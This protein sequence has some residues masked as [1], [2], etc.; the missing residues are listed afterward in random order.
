[1][2]TEPEP[3]G[4]APGGSS[5]NARWLARVVT[6]LLA[7]AGLIW[8]ASV[9]A[10]L[11]DPAIPRVASRVA[12][13]ESYDPAL[14]RRMVAEN[15]QSAQR[16]CNAK[17]LRQ[18][19]ILQIGAAE[20]SIR[21]PDLRQADADIADIAQMSRTLLGCAPTESI[22]WLGAYWSNIRQEGFGPRAAVYLG[23]SYRSA[24]HEAWIQLVR[25]P[26]ALRSF[27]ALSPELK[28]A[29]LQD[30]DD[31][32]RAQLFSSAAMLLKT[33]VASAQATLL[34]RSCD[35]PERDRLL[36]RHFVEEAG[37]DIHHR[38]YPRDDRP[39]YMRD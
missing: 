19:L 37:V 26:L 27:D 35:V 16:L 10:N 4:T 17:V 21:D 2:S 29:A 7:V 18:L 1:M 20:G 23:Q 25:A 14:L 36:F 33:A 12:R 9:S 22:G 28:Q 8:V 13:G 34:D 11:S 24:P 15:L 38:C 5:A 30:F 32:F 3:A 31:I 39:A 6:I